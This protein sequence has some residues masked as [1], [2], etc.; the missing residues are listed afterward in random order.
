[1]PAVTSGKVLVTGANGYI[2]FWVVKALLE[3]GYAVRGTVRSGEKGAHLK[4]VF[5]AYGDKLEDGAFDEA[6]KGVD[7]IEHTASPFHFNVQ[8]PA[9]LITPAVAGTGSVLQSALKFG[10]D[11]KRV[12]ILSS[13]AAVIDSSKPGPTTF[14]EADWNDYSINE[15]ETKGRDATPADKY[16][17]SK[18][19]AERAAWKFYENNKAQLS[20]DLVVLN[21]PFVFGPVLHAVD[22]PESLNTS[23]KDWYNYVLKG[24]GDE[25][26][27]VSGGSCWVDVRDLAYA[28]VLAIEKE[29]AAGNRIIV[30]AG[31]FKWQ[32]FVNEARK[33]APEILPG[34]TSYTPGTYPV[35]YDTTRAARLLG[36]TY[37]SKAETTRDTIADFKQKGWF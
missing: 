37:R 6:V 33:L 36:I 35:N 2:A 4:D 16:R 32:D 1:M 29:E 15:V 7:A 22:S 9:E 12:V 31:P 5:K 10:T 17:A 14:S 34:N 27:L 30:S 18:T 8:D 25:N 23:A 24:K 11:V 13:C 26:F 3:K 19:L 28:H 20:W 21:P